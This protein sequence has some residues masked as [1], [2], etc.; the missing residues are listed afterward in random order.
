VTALPVIPRE[1]AARDADG[2]LDHYLGEGAAQAALGFIDALEH[3]YDHVARHPATGSPRYPQ[4]LNL[5]GLRAWPLAGYPHVVFYVE[6][7]D[8][9][10]V[11]RVLHA[12]RDIPAWLQDPEPPP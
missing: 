4:A 6:Q 12:S 8:C 2:A 1:R 11:W 5:P 3:A 7:A 9:I 10:D